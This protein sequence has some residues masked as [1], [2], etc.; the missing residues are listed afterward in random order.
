MVA[1]ASHLASAKV[2]PL[3]AGGEVA[4]RLRLIG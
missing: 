4:V 3:D 2:M 1:G